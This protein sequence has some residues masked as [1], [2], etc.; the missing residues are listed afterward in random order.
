[1]RSFIVD[2]SNR[3]IVKDKN[4][5]PAA[6]PGSFEIDKDN[7]LIYKLKRSIALEREFGLSK[8]LIFEGKWKLNKNYDL[9]LI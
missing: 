5:K 4:K 1:M 6:L 3:L 8:E 9:E 7:R 2:Q